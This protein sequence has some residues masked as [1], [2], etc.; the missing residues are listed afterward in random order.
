MYNKITMIKNYIKIAIRNLLKQKGLASI[1]IFGLSIGLA[2]FSL[3]VLYAVHEFSFDQF[4]ESGDQI[5]RMYRWSEDLDGEGTEGDPHLPM[6]LGAALVEGFPDVEEIVRWKAAWGEN[7]VKVNGQT[8]RAEVS[9]VDK[10]VFELFSFPLKYGTPASA[11]A[12]PKNVV[13]TEEMAKKLFG[14]SNPTGKT[15]EIKLEENFEPFTVAA[16]AENLPSNSSMQFQIMGSFDY[17][18]STSYGKRRANNWGSSFLPVFVKLRDGSGLATNE[19]ALLKFR[20]KYYPDQEKELREEGRW[21]GEGAPVTYRL[22]PLK[23]L[24]TDS[25]IYGFDIPTIDT[26]NIWILLAIAAGVLLIAIINFTTLSIGRSA[27]RAKEVGIRKVVGSTRKQL[28][29]QFLTESFLLSVIS[30]VIG[31]GLAQLLLPYFNDLS[32]RELVFSFTQFPEMTWLMASV[33]LLTGFFAG[34]YPA[35]ILSR[36]RSVDVLKNKIKLGGANFF[37]KSLVTTQFALSSGLVIATL[38]ILSQLN[39]LQ[40]KNPGF[41]K[42]NIIVVEAEEMNTEEVYPR[43]K[44]AL[45]KN[46]NILGIASSELG[47]GAGTGWSRSGFDYKGENKQVFEYFVDD[48]YLNVLGM[49]LLKGRDFDAER[50]DGANRSVI[51]NEAMVKNFGW[52]LE[53]AVGQELTGYFEESP[54]PKVIGVVKDFHFRP[55]N[56]EVRPQMFHQYEDYAPFKFFVRIKAGDPS[57]VLADLKTTWKGIAPNFPFK[58]SF[59]DDDLNRFYRSEERFSKTISWAGGISIFLACLGLMGLAALAAVNRTKEIGIRKVL[60]ASVA[61]IVG[62]LSKDFIKLVFIALIIASPIAWYLMSDWLE[63]FA[64]RIDIQWWMFALAGFSAVG[65]AFLTV[66]FQ[67]VKAA[68]TNPIESLRSE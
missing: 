11:L 15:I 55:F 26:K 39:F 4:H 2:C 29:S 24:H 42:E 8:S 44:D 68:L 28:A 12:D 43:F 60:G 19:E 65:I 67:S 27:G 66:S 49:E 34:S 62:L 47:L 63:D 64:Y 5:Y 59:L 22:Q 35:L 61:G 20:Q 14:E 54:E 21:T 18:A 45:N 57:P 53:N 25:R 52:T 51:V 46:P 37:T 56:E 3:F 1:N 13:L 50:Q 40:S 9:H 30:A 17:F 33:I 31:L 16:V 41:N 58:Y 23:E 38:V 48:D 32:G 7:F 36:F 10:S 6:P